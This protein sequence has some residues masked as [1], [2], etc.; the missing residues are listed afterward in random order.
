MKITI[1]DPKTGKTYQ[2]EID[3]SQAS[4]LYGKKIG[5]EIDLSDI[6]LGGFKG[7]ITGGS[8]KQGFPM[9]KDVH[10][11]GRT[12]V[13]LTYGVG[14][15][16]KGKGLRKRKTVRGNTISGE[17]AQVNIK[18]TETSGQDIAKVFGGEEKKDEETTKE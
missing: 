18:V 17:I 1:A 4:A 3:E 8:D 9:R 2:K 15:K 6:G 10:G 5:A 12:K 14:M 13:L 16:E 7:V 11:T